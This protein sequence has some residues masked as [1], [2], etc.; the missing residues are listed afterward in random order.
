MSVA[1]LDLSFHQ[2]GA[3]IIYLQEEYWYATIHHQH[4][5]PLHPPSLASPH[6]SWIVELCNLLASRIPYTAILLLRTL[7]MSLW[8]HL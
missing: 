6:P 1:V 5:S 7:Y 3:Y 8:I 4:P 2:H